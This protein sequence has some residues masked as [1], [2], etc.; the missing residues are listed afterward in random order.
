M[1]MEGDEV[2]VGEYTVRCKLG[3][4]ASSTVWK[5]E[6]RTS[7]K[8]VALKQ[9]ERHKL[10]RQL[11]NCLDCEL[12]FLSSVHH[13]N[14]ISLFDVFL[15][16]NSTFLVLE[17]CAGGDLASYIQNHG[18]VQECVARKFMK[19]I[20]A[21]LEVLSMHQIIH[22]DL[23]PENILLSSMEDDP[24]LKIADFGLSRMLNPNDLAE[25]VCGSPFYMAPE[26]LQF[27]KYDDKVDMWSLGAILFELL[28]GYPPFRGRT[29]VQI[30]QNIKASLRLPFH[31]PILLQLH[32]DCV[33]LCS[34]LLS[35]D[36]EKRISFKEFCQ[37]DFLKIDER[38]R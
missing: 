16:E 32:P 26:I 38:G 22:R 24:I 18:R 17:F 35:I 36:P 12:T 23:K 29:S 19:Q 15:A 2:T 37:H 21:G 1:K 34:R 10:T 25:T 20:G 5:A 7:G 28:N 4:G 31:E 3:G 14:I 33:D 6:H 9:I 13:P 8:V 11:K 27:K 30:L